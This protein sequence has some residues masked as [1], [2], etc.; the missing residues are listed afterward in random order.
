MKHVKEKE[1]PGVGPATVRSPGHAFHPA[2]AHC[3][4][5]CRQRVQACV[6]PDLSSDLGA[7]DHGALDLGAKW[8]IAGKCNLGGG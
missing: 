1:R 4:W 7:L 5:L 2:Q 6:S 3:P 8:E